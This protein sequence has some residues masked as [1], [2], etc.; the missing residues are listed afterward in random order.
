MNYQELN[1]TSFNNSI[2][3][4]ATRLEELAQLQTSLQMKI[5]LL[6][7]SLSKHQLQTEDDFEQLQTIIINQFLQNNHTHQLEGINDCVE[8][9]AAITYMWRHRMATCCVPEYD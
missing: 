7:A 2:H 6:N 4:L 8:L 3:Q 1:L 9:A 5:E